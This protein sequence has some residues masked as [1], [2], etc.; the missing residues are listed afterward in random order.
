MS[1]S[2]APQ[3]KA[4]NGESP[5]FLTRLD[6]LP[7]CLSRQWQ[8]FGCFHINVYLNQFITVASPGG[9]M[10][11]DNQGLFWVLLL[12]CLPRCLWELERFILPHRWQSEGLQ[13][14]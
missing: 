13:T 1:C 7:W 2:G 5:A 10:K 4:V 9:S 3:Q 11:K 14:K 6:P 12:F 8:R